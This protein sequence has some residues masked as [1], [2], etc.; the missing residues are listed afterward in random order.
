MPNPEIESYS[1]KI[2]KAV[3]SIPPALCY[4]LALT[5]AIVDFTTDEMPTV[6]IL[7]GISLGLAIS[8]G[9]HNKGLR[10]ENDNIKQT[11]DVESSGDISFVEMV[12]AKAPLL[13]EYSH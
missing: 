5:C 11:H 10:E 8:N 2:G 6:G 4:S 7:G 13:S 1:S 12:T 3:R 9:L